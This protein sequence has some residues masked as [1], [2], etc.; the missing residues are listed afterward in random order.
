MAILQPGLGENG[1]RTKIYLFFIFF[2]L[3]HLSLA[4]N[5]AKMTFLNFLN[6]FTIFFEFFSEYSSLSRA[7]MVTQMKFSFSFSF[8]ACLNSIWIEMKSEWRFLDFSIFYYFLELFWECSILGRAQPIL[9]K[10][11][12]FFSF[13]AYPSLIWLENFLFS[14][15]A[16]FLLF[17]LN[18][19]RKAPTW[20]G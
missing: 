15:F 3:S 8:S 13:L 12:F 19:L 17:A 7:E 14:F 18:F 20:V 11:I 6:F 9:G 4:R 2:G 10:K 1:T 16:F 5:E